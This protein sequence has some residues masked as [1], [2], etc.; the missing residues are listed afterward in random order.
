MS[1]VS[2]SVCQQSHDARSMHQ[3]P[4]CSAY[5]CPRCQQDNAGYCTSCAEEEV[6]VE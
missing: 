4:S 1:K 6:A 2:C 5:V 3:C